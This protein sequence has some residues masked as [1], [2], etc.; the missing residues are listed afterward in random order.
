MKLQD[1]Y[2]N[3]TNKKINISF[4]VFPPKEEE[5]SKKLMEELNVLKS[6]NPEFISLTWGAG[7]NE[8]KSTDLIK[9]IKSLGIEVMPHFTCVCST[10][11][12]VKSHIQVLEELN[13]ENI[14]A[15]RGDMPE[16][17]SLCS[18]DFKY[19]NEL[20][21]FLK[22]NSDLSIGVA[23]YPEGHIEAANL[24]EDIK[25]LNQKVA[26]GAAAIFTQLFFDNE[27]FFRYC[28]LVRKN[29]I[30]IPIIP[31]L[32]PIL[33]KKQIDKMTTLAKITIPSQLQEKIEKYQDSNSD[34]QKMGIEYA[35]N[36]CEEL[37]KANVPGLHF[38]TLNK[39]KSTKAILENIL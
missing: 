16:D 27:K 5:Q 8:N 12:F 21:E 28:E 1:I 20:V 37:L 33:S 3:N 36:Q 24:T 14:L 6:F 17:K 31:G 35:I 23:G 13:I 10:K 11:E 7:G 18:N 29:G 25:N 30:T 26:A 9:R 32:L 4:E 38:F 15:L 39:S 34:M 22:A 2:Q 19:A